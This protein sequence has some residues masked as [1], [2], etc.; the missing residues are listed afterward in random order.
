[1]A[2]HAGGDSYRLCK[3]PEDPFSF[4]TE[5]CFQMGAMKYHGNKSWIQYGADRNNRT[6]IDAVRVDVD[7]IQWSRNPIPAC[8]DVY[9]GNARGMTDYPNSGIL[10]AGEECSHPQF[11][12]PIEGLFGYALAQCQFPPNPNIFSNV[13]LEYDDDR[14]CTPE[15][16]KLVL[17]RWNFNIVD[18]VEVPADIEPGEYVMSWR[19]DCE[20][21]AQVW[22]SCA[23]IT[24]I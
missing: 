9:G 11:E 18:L 2:N 14:V 3:K 12:P 16:T 13:G 4:V 15:F 7:G 19:H 21:S 22:A 6:E 5:E 10:Q 23:D 17:E 8:G 1:M 24:I 20:Q